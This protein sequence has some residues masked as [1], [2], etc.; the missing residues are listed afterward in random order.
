[1]SARTPPRG[2]RRAR[3]AL[4]LAALTSAPVVLAATAFTAG[5]PIA[6]LPASLNEV[7][8]MAH[9]RANRDVFWVHNDSGDRPRAYAV[10][11]S[12][13]LLGTYLLS[14]ATAVDWEDMA[15]GPAP[16]GA[17]YLYLADIGDN[18]GR[19]RSVRIYRVLEPRVDSSRVD[20]HAT[21]TG[22]TSYEFVYDDGPRD[23]E[24]FMVDPLTGDFYVVSKWESSGSRLYRAAAPSATGINTFTHVGTFPFHFTTAGDIS[25]DGLQ[26]LI[27]RYSD[28]TIN[29]LTPPATSAS[30]W[31]RADAKTSLVDLLAQPGTTVPLARE[32]QGEAIAFDAD[33]RGFYTTGERGL[34]PASR[35][36]RVPIY[37][38]AMK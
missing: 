6:Y 33:G 7:S 29:P 23:A 24:A 26:V 17:S 34:L 20:V 27:R 14:G 38:Y 31:R 3:L 11:R 8:G 13:S 21:L 4:S 30:Y 9:S 10:G 22:V 37:F 19:R 36:D 32:P 35:R 5:T 18:L 25:A 2:G 16:G 28:D 15:I 12:G 1:L